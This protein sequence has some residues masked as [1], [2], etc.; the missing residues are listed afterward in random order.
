MSL[1]GTK[2]GGK[3]RFMKAGA[4]LSLILLILS[5]CNGVSRRSSSSSESPGNSQEFSY[6]HS[7]FVLELKNVEVF[8]NEIK[9]SFMYTNRTGAQQL[10]YPRFCQ[11]RDNIQAPRSGA[12]GGA[13]AVYL[14][15]N[16]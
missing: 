14:V 11:G 8:D 2:T 5:A 13:N 16:L 3:W 4:T 12:G 1:R 7:L 10:A 9:M 6:R 15:D